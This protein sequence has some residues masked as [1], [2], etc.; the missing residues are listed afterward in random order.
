VLPVIIPTNNLTKGQKMTLEE[1]KEMVIAQ[2]EASKAE[3]LA[4][5]SKGVNK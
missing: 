2:R 1:Y 5:L 3:A 4:L